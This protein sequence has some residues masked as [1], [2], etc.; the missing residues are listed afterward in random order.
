[1]DKITL[2]DVLVIL[3]EVPKTESRGFESQ[4]N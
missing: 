1:M 4:Q 3:Q 2:V